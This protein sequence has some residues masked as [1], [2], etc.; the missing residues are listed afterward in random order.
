MTHSS[1]QV[2][3][4]DSTLLVDIEVLWSHGNIDLAP[5]YFLKNSYVFL[6]LLIGRYLAAKSE[7]NG[8]IIF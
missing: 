3:E 2:K 7:V 1:A 5:V 8:N 6:L 4:V